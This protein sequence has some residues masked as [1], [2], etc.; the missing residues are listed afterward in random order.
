MAS[1]TAIE[2][3]ENSNVGMGQMAIAKAPVCL[4]AVLGSCIGVALYHRRLRLG[5]LSH[6]VLPDSN[7]RAAASPGKFADTAI[8]EM[9]RVLAEH[10]AYPPG[11]TAKIAGG[12]CMFG[13][14][15]PM[16]VGQTNEQAVTQMLRDAGIS[17][18]AQDVGGTAGRR[19]CFDCA[20]GAV[21]I[22]CAGKPTRTL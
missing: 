16:Q 13:A 4:T 19:I 15:G 7:G 14:S 5:M 6:V 18:T 8:P 12:A 11:L 21:S 20:T 9:L 10:S 17:I 3:T 1:C 2:T 22:D